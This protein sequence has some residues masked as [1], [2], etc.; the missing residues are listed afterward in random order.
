MSESQDLYVRVIG[1]ASKR[2]GKFTLG[3]MI[4]SLELSEQ[5]NIVVRKEIAA[6]R[7][8]ATDMMAY[9]VEATDLRWQSVEVWCTAED[10]FRYLE[11]EQLQFARSEA[12]KAGKQA[13]FATWLAGV[14]FLLNVVGIVAG[15][16]A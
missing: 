14:G 11:F 16:V 4:S 1:W 15:I 7:L 3:E 2:A 5:Q 13:R 10:R 12:E 6:K 9:V 8:L